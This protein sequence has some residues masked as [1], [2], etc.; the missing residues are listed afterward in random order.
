[1]RVWQEF[2]CNDCNGFFTVKIN[3][4][5]NQQILL[6]CPGPDCT[7]K[8]PRNIKN[9]IIYEGGREDHGEEIIVPKSAYSKKP[10]TKAMLERYKPRGG[11]AITERDPMADAIIRDSWIERFGHT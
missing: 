3:L 4:A 6:C 5:L 7:R 8:H 9:G 11:V 1:M 10:L 2:Y